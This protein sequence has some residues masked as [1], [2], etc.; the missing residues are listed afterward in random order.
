MSIEH[1][2]FALVKFETQHWSITS[3]LAAL[4]KGLWDGLENDFWPVMSLDHSCFALLEIKTLVGLNNYQC[5]SS[6]FR[7]GLWDGLANAFWQ[8]WRVK[9]KLCLYINWTLVL[10]T[11]EFKTQHWSI[12]SV[13]AALFKRDFETAWR[14]IFDEL[15]QLTTRAL[16]LWK[17]KHS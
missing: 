5:V 13:L 9:K 6:I 14:I 4:W 2:W 10:R 12:I 1:S 3:V 15:C 8:I 7:K 11:H 17:L 16:H